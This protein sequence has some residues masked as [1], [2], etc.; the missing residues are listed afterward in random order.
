MV[1]AAAGLSGRDET[2][3]SPPTA[4][5]TPGEEMAGPPAPEAAASLEISRLR[6]GAPPFTW[7]GEG[8][9]THLASFVTDSD[10]RCSIVAWARARGLPAEAIRWE[11]TPPAGF[12]LP[13]GA[14]PNG[15]VLR[16]TLTRRDGNPKGGG[17]PLAITVRA[18]A[19]QGGRSWEASQTISQ[20]ERDVMRQ[21]YVDLG[22]ESVPERYRFLDAA[23]YAE[24]YGRRFPQIRFEELNWS[25]NPA[26]G[27]RYRFILVAERLLEGLARTRERYGRPLLFNSGY[28]NPTRQ[29]EVHAPVKESL[30]QYGLAADL[31][32]LPD[33]TASQDGTAAPSPQDWLSFAEAATAAGASW[34]EPLSESGGHLHVDFREGGQRSGQVTLKGRVLDVETGEPVAG[35]R[36]LLA[37]MP[38]ASDAA[39]RFAL[40]HVLTPRERDVAVTAE[41]YQPLS[42]AVPIRT[43]SNSVDFRLAS[44]PRPRLVAHIGVAAWAN[45]AS[46]LA[47]AELRLR[48]TGE[49]AARNLSLVAAAPQGAPPPVAVAPARLDTLAVGAEATIRLTFKV[50]AKEEPTPEKVVLRLKGGDAEGV[51]RSQRLVAEWTPPARTPLREGKTTPKPAHAAVG[52]AALGATAVVGATTVVRRRAA[53]PGPAP[54]EARPRSMPAKPPAEIPPATDPPPPANALPTAGE[55]AHGAPPREPEPVSSPSSPAG[56]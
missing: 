23:R 28:R 27:E 5:R 14:L 32:V 47:T 40:R 3:P 15:P 2:V 9:A 30:H 56:P 38:A 31:A 46:G 10:R 50:G 36:V 8:D 4:A 43:G 54:P 6:V 1:A 11:V 16:V 18:R 22:R 24:Q 7:A 17:G 26:T 35:A 41:G 33:V 12:S 42:Q 29:V 51:A 55:T 49:R 37:G 13:A 53:K 25:V 21:E 44:G 48:N 20:D 19:Q 52:A 39:G 45:E 34:V